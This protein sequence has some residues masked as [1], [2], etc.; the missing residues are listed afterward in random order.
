MR[1]SLRLSLFVLL[2]I[3]FLAIPTHAHAQLL[4]GSDDTNTGPDNQNNSGACDGTMNADQCMWSPMSGQSGQYYY[5]AAK[6]RWG[7]YCIDLLLKA[8]T[9]NTWQ[10]MNVKYQAHCTCDASARTTRG[11]CTYE[12]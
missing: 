7:G 5:C 6:G 4:G 12:Y 9:T 2:A 11:M 10:C 1:T 8:G 3:V